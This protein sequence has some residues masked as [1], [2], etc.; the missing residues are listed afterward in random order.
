MYNKCIQLS[1]EDLRLVLTG[2]M[3]KVGEPKA[4]SRICSQHFVGNEKSNHPHNPAFLPTIF[5]EVSAI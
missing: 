3:M 5:P 4:H 2:R 1:K